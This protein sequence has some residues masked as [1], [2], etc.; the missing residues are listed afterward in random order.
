MKRRTVLAL[1]TAGVPVVT[2][3]EAF[4]GFQPSARAAEIMVYKDPNCGCC[5]QRVAGDGAGIEAGALSCH[6]L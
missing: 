2:G 3:R 6:S 5:G 1:I 4:L